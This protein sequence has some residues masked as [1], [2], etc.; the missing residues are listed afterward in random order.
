MSQNKQ[1]L[2]KAHE[3]V[4]SKKNNIDPNDGFLKQLKEYEISIFS[5]NC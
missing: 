2:E 1:T 3:Y 5:E 4:L